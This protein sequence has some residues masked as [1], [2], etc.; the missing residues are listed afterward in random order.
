M[1]PYTSKCVLDC[2][3]VLRPVPG[4]QN[5]PKRLECET[6]GYP[7]EKRSALFDSK[8]DGDPPNDY[9]NEIAPP[10]E[11]I[12]NGDGDVVSSQY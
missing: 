11:L 1:T 8:P 6:H 7:E 9:L 2:N 12:Q 4:A 10:A 5:W 3:L